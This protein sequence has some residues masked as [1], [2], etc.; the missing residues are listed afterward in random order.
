[1]DKSKG[2]E[3]ILVLG[4]AKSGK[5]S[6]ALRYAEEHHKSCLFLATAEV[7][8]KEMAE[9]VRLHKESRGPHW[10][11][12]EEPLN[13][14]E[15]LQTGCAQADAVLI[16]CVTIW[17]SNILL[18]KGREKIIPYQDRL[19]EALS[20]R[21]QAVIVVSNE[22]GAG[23]VPEHPLGREFRDLAGMLNQKLAAMADKVVM[24]VAGIPVRIK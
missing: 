14:A 10:K 4:G 2:N 7:K 20:R 1:M 18:K 22:V 15:A 19:L 23:I 16:D 5:S 17:L 21:Q 12:I 13:I 24:T 9:R 11:L 6:W 8:D 3:F